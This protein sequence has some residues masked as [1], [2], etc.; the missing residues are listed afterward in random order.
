MVTWGKD[1]LPYEAN[2]NRAISFQSLTF[3][4]NRIDARGP[5]GMGSLN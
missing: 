5:T 3:L 2:Y 4:I 1:P